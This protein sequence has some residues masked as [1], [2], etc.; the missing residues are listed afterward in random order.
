MPTTRFGAEEFGEGLIKVGCPNSR[1]G[2]G[3]VHG[4][5]EGRSV[6]GHCASKGA[7]MTR[8]A[9]IVFFILGKKLSERRA[10][11]ASLKITQQKICSM[12]LWY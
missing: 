11:A 7:A 2:S 1:V 12:Y 3:L 10:G 4:V 9:K 6:F 8:I 5:P